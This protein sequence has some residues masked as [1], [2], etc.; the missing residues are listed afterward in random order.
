MHACGVSGLGAGKGGGGRELKSKKYLFMGTPE[1][2]VAQWTS[3]RLL[4]DGTLH[5][6]LAVQQ[7]RMR[8]KT[9]Q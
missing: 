1:D 5:S 6:T 9:S 2:S 7:R 4:Q 8:V 3:Q